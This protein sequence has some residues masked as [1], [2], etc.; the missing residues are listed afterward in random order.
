MYCII[1]LPDTTGRVPTAQELRQRGF[2]VSTA[3]E[4]PHA[5]LAGSAAPA[6][7]HRNP[8]ACMP[9]SAVAA[10][11]LTPYGAPQAPGS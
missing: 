9:T 3:V 11:E 4:P 7:L 2:V 10:E 1:L 8:S 5:P 6:Q